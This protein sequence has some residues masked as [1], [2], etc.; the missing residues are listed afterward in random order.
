[1]EHVGGRY[2]ETFGVPIVRGRTF[3]EHDFPGCG[4]EHARES[5]TP[6][7]INQTAEQRIFGAGSA[8][9]RGL[10]ADDDGRGCVVVGA[11][12]DVRPGLLNMTPNTPVATAFAP[13]P[14]ARFRS[15][16][17]QGTTVLLRVMS[18]RSAM[19]AVGGELRRTH[20]RLTI[21]DARTMD[22]YLERFERVVRIGVGQLA[23]LSLS[24]SCSLPSV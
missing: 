16:W 5:E 21:F 3:T 11:V 1:M 4:A 20:S 23:G 10:W 14:V 9:G 6:V 15:A 7:V 13:V 19:A 8:V 12:P 17:I 18:E 22:E 2:F 24:G